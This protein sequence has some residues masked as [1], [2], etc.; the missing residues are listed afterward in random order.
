MTHADS[1][2]A[3]H[4]CS[5]RAL[6]V[7]SVRVGLQ[8][9]LSGPSLTTHYPK[10]GMSGIVPLS[11]PDVRLSKDGELWGAHLLETNRSAA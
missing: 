11:I 5:G 9:L 4:G 8:D 6:P 3:A 2:N 1:H 10:L 7:Q